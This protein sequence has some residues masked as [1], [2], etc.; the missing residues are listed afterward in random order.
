MRRFRIALFWSVLAIAVALPI[1]AA[2]TSPLLAW[3]D[4]VYIVAGFAGVIAMTLILFQPM[5]AA[6]YLP[7]ISASR[8][9]RIHQWVGIALV[10]SVVIHVA[11]LWVTSPPDVID[12]LLFVSATPFSNWGVIAMWGVFISACLAASRHSLRLRP[13]TWRV[14]HRTL[15]AVIVIGS[16]VHAMMIE[17]TMETLSKSALCLLVL[18]ATAVVLADLQQRKLSF[19]R[20]CIE[21]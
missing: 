1:G 2:A 4:P 13:R 10:L 11:G 9:R 5:L 20:D 14:S 7:G 12:A 19:K 8:G 6:G 18:I 21:K 16:V 3:R 17:G 15:A